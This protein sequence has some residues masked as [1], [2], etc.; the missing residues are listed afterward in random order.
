MS[1]NHYFYIG[2]A[3]LKVSDS[4]WQLLTASDSCGQLLT[5]FDHCWQLLTVIDSFW[6]VAY[7][8]L[9][10]AQ[11]P[12]SFR[13]YWVG[14]KGF[15]TGLD[16]YFLF[17]PLELYSEVIRL[18]T[19]LIIGSWKAHGFSRITMDLIKR[20]I[21]RPFAYTFNWYHL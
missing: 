11:V 21:F 10:S 14:T 1:S 16:N 17:N 20:F 15:R 2:T 6:Q 8:I 19:K 5:V 18:V 7:S 9:V 12:F 13:F 3:Q 4:C